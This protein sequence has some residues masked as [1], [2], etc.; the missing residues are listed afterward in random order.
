MSDSKMFTVSD[1]QI[2][3]VLRI[4]TNCGDNVLHLPDSSIIYGTLSKNQKKKEIKKAKKNLDAMVD[5]LAHE[6]N[7]RIL[8]EIENREEDEQD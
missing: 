4:I 2:D 5:D 8:K 7:I 3:S 1:S 6:I